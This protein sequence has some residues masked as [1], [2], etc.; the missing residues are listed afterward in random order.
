MAEVAIAVASMAAEVDPVHH[1]SDSLS[2]GFEKID[3]T[4]DNLAGCLAPKDKEDG[5][6]RERGN[7]TRVRHRH[8]RWAVEDDEIIAI[9]EIGQRASHRLGLENLGSIWRIGSRTDDID[10]SR[11]HRMEAV[12][13]GFGPQQ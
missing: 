1:D 10:I 11:R 6:V 7:D 4:G 9:F 3:G 12:L 13:Q 5:V 8:D 2:R